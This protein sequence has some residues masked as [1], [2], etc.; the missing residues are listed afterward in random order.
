MIL[1]R[2]ST[3]AR[4]QRLTA[5]RPWRVVAG[6]RLR[7]PGFA[8]AV[9]LA[10]G[11]AG[12]SRAQDA[13]RAQEAPSIGV[14]EI[15]RGQRG[16][17]VSVFAGTE[18]E[19]FDVE[20]VGVLRDMSPGVSFIL[21]RLSGQG[22]ENTGVVG[23]MSGSPVYIDDRLAGAVAF[24]W[25]FASDAIAG[26][27]PI[28]QM[29]KLS[30]LP[31]AGPTPRSVGGLGSPKTLLELVA[32]RRGPDPAQM[33]REQL[34]AAVPSSALGR[35]PSL[36]FAARGFGDGARELLGSALAPLGPLAAAGRVENGSDLGALLPGSSV[37][38][39]L[40][41][42]DLELA[43]SGTVTE[44]RVDEERGDEVL[45]F[46]HAF[47]SI[48]PLRMPL[49]PAEVVSV[50]PSRFSSFKLTNVGSVIGAFDQ[51][52]LTGLRGRIGLEAKTTPVE[53]RV[54]GVTHRDGAP[55]RDYH[56]E[57]ADI[58]AMRP[59]LVGISALQ[60]LD[61]AARSNGDLGVDLWM[62]FDLS[63]WG[64]LETRQ[65]F[66]GSGAGI[67]AAVHLLQL[68]GFLELNPWVD[69]EVAAIE[70]EF[71]VAEQPRSATIEAVHPSRRQVA[72]GETI[73]LRL[74]LVGYRGERSM[75]TVSVEIPA[76][77]PRGNYHLFVGD[78]MSVDAARLRIE[79]GAPRDFAAALRQLASYHARD[80]LAILG[81]RPADP[82]LSVSG[83]SLPSL[84]G[85]I[86]AI[87]QGADLVDTR[88]LGLAIRQHVIQSFERP[89]DGLVRVDLEIVEPRT[90]S[91]RTGRSGG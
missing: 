60:A 85:S 39:V 38:G 12:G 67:D 36:A 20:V 37:A 43:V 58:P 48:G 9:A 1:A 21:A 68:V 70:I 49:A 88:P 33:L 18:L 76:D 84:P 53:I 51:D 52:R 19:R 71:Q 31:A 14:E 11:S 74:E 59:G 89:L 30:A 79:P 66:D 8:L 69:V 27:T 35:Q 17:G 45:A 54:R 4:S 6:R 57:I 82:G 72:P 15:V 75:S 81:V 47:L 80:Q 34:G 3:G 62:R 50:V 16:Y 29:R 5:D 32:G 64:I 61:A 46:G 73:D 86:R 77:T 13:S 90:G 41:G 87:W 55:H 28:A 26:I 91:S 23:G 44:I 40:V 24:S 2:E 56:L 22:L 7:A 42:G 78:G 65:T 25:N 83:R 10:L 63:D